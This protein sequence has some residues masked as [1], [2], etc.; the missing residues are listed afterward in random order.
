MTQV[1]TMR[2]QKIK[3]KPED[4]QQKSFKRSADLERF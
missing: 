2:F 3:Q 4:L 1:G